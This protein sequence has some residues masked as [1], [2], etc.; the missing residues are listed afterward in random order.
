MT[1]KDINIH[2]K[3]KKLELLN[4]EFNDPHWN[5][6]HSHSNAKI[7]I[8]NISTSEFFE[9]QKVLLSELRY[10]FN[11]EKE[12]YSDKT[13][14]GKCKLFRLFNL[15]LLNEQI[16]IRKISDINYDVLEKY[17]NLLSYENGAYRKHIEIKKILNEMKKYKEIKL[18]EDINNN[19]IPVAF[20]ERNEKSSSVEYYTNEEYYNLCN[21]IK[22]LTKNY[23]LGLDDEIKESHFINAAYFL[24]SIC[25]GLNK[26]GLK[27][28]PLIY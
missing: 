20:F 12:Y 18:S 23:I 13:L 10:Y 19:N 25:T 6:N 2:K 3:E 5:I 11:M 9:Q 24:I 7:N 1:I 27:T 22:A 8:I 21:M 15:S 4:Y 26:T 14:S 17:F 16:I 28:V